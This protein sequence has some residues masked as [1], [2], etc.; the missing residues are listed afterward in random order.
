MT[1]AELLRARASLIVS[2]VSL[3][4]STEWLS[5]M[6]RRL[7][8]GSDF[9]DPRQKVRTLPDTSYSLCGYDA[10]NISYQILA[11]KR[12]VAVLKRNLSLVSYVL[13]I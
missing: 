10:C 9:A 5:S 7:I 11:S 3:E 6:V 13:A 1:D 8:Y 12:L 4:N 2:L